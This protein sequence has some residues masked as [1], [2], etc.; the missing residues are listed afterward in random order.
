MYSDN[1]RVVSGKFRLQAVHHHSSGD[2]SVCPVQMKYVYSAGWWSCAVGLYSFHINSKLDW[3][4][5][6]SI[7]TKAD[8][9]M[10]QL[11]LLFE[12]VAADNEAA[13]LLP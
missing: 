12:Y 3:D 5:L 4:C 8:Q 10:T 13:N 1:G 2:W 6:E 9:N 7:V 11:N